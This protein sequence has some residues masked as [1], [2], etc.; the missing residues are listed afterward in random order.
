MF[1]P[2]WRISDRGI[3]DRCITLIDFVSVCVCDFHWKNVCSVAE[4]DI[5]LF[6]VESA[7]Q[8]EMWV[9]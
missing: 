8:Y 6:W 9:W 4:S 5:F 3:R 7:R 1:R 2:L